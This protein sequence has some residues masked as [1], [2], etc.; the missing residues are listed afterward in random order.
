MKVSPEVRARRTANGALSTL[1]VLTHLK[2][3]QPE[4]WKIAQ[5][6]GGWQQ[7]SAQRD[8]LLAACKHALAKLEHTWP[9]IK[10][11][12]DFEPELRQAIAECQGGDK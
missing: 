9:L 7:L 10:D 6:I 12:K 3:E 4:A 8:R 11:R 5:V 1:D 2:A